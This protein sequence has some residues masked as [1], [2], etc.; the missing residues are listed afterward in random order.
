[1]RPKE[2]GPTAG[3]VMLLLIIL[4]IV[5]WLAYVMLS[6]NVAWGPTG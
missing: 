5:G 6:G 3:S 1:M 2:Q 4:G